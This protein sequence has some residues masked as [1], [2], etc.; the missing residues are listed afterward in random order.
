M[1]YKTITFELLQNRPQLYDQLIIN[2]TLL[3]TL[4]RY[5]EELRD[6]HHAWMGRLWQAKPASQASQIASEAL[7]LALEEMK[8]RLPPVSPAVESEPL[9]LDAAMRFIRPYT[10]NA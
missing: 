7:E 2:R 8:R 3:Q 1:N 9:S 5:A 4:N 10:Q 6:I